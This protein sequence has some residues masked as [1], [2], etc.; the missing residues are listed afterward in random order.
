MTIKVAN[1]VDHHMVEKDLARKIS[2]VPKASQVGLR[3]FHS[4]VEISVVHNRN[5]GGRSAF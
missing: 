3:H 1:M 2:Y 4:I 5:A